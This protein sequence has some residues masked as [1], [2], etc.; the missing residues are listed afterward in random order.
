MPLGKHGAWAEFGQR[1]DLP[2]GEVIVEPADRTKAARAAVLAIDLC[3]SRRRCRRSGGSLR[4]GG[5]IPVGLGMGS[6][7]SDIIATVRAVAASYHV[8]LTAETIAELAVRAECASDPL[9]MSDR[10]WL[11]AQREGRIVEVLG[12]TLPS[13]VVVGC[14]VG[15]GEPVD[16][17]SLP[18]VEYDA[19][20]IGEYERLRAMLRSAV[21]RGDVRLFGRVCTE[22]ARAN[23]RVLVKP[24]L[25]RLEELADA[26]GA[27]GVQIAHSGNVAGLLFDPDTSS[28][29]ARVRRSVAE[30]RAGGLSLTSVFTVG[31]RR[32]AATVPERKR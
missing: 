17:L 4:L 24:E 10:P 16:T 21:I 25:G 9:M 29:R 31:A 28:L 5:D 12:S 32:R 11:F 1:P 20:D 13:A 18:T 23:Q 8:S 6:S 30:L 2:T 19:D 3:A 22:S 27:V 15:H 14:A 7:T 26:V